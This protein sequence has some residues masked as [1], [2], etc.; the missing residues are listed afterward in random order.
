MTRLFL[1]A[2]AACLAPLCTPAASAP[3]PTS[4]GEH[5]L[6]V[7]GVRLW[8]RV[9]G[10]SGG[11]PLVFLHGG[12]G[13]GSQTF[14]AVGGPEL[15]KTQ[16]LVYLDQRGSGRSD[17][18]RDPS[19]YSI[20]IM[21]EDIEQLRRHLG[22]P[23]IA[24]LGHSF[25]SQ[26]ALEYAAR[27]PQ[28]THAVVLAAAA[29]HLTR[30]IDLQCERLAV[31]DPEA[32][33][34][35]AAGIRAGAVPRCNTMSA[36]SG[37]AATAFAHRNLFPDP[38]TAR[39]VTELDA[40]GGLGATGEAARALFQKGYLQYRFSRAADVAAPV[41]IIAGGKDFQTAIEPQR[42]LVKELPRGRL[43]EYPEGGHFMFVETPERFAR[44]VAAF[45]RERAPR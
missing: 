9:A 11:I 21:V 23:K 19:H 27:Y 41:L 25:G 2:A 15:E 16:R 28:R 36:Y 45:L 31:E 33:A 6:V 37:D 40:A 22:V 35:A 38:A 24:L 1:L 10:R 30:S 8:Y 44:D 17:R 26:L 7:N 13:Q 43:L 3:P 29:A 42:D 34:R 12:P 20:D 39:R 32:Y 18:P 4:I 14:Q 5:H